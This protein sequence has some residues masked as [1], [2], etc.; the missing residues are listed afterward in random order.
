MKNQQYLYKLEANILMRAIPIVVNIAVW[1]LPPYTRSGI[2]VIIT[3]D[4]VLSGD[5]RVVNTRATITSVAL[6]LFK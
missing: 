5:V 6:E 2:A 3:V 1:L 4:L